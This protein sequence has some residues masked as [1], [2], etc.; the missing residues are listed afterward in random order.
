MAYRGDDAGAALEAPTADGPLRV[1]LGPRRVTLAVAERSL[2]IAERFA[3]I[4]DGT[5]RVS[6]KLDGKLI[7]AR[8]VPHEDLGVWVEVGD[9]MRRIFGVPPV[10]LLEPDGLAAL[11]RLDIVAH[12]LRAELAE[13]AGDIRKA[14]ELGRGLDKVLLA[15]HG[16]R[17]A[18][19][20]RR[21]FRDRARLAVE[22][23]D[24]GRIRIADGKELRVTSR[25][26]VTVRGDYLRFA[27]AHGTDLGRVAIPWIGPEDR[28]ELARRIGQLVDKP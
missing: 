1:E 24:D 13:L 2:Q 17:Y 20:A 21:L 10:S 25:F 27:D 26:S 19:Y 8:D 7:V 16:D 23:F 14:V 18:V 12:R 5:K 15:D 9:G 11:R 28:H 3:T 4:V 6:L 22:I